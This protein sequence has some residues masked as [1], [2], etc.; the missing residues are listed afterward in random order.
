MNKKDGI[1]FMKDVI[2]TKAEGE[3]A[4]VLQVQV[5]MMFLNLNSASRVM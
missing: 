4:F 1:V 5:K 2:A 3:I